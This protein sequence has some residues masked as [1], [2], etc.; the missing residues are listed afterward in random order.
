MLYYTLVKSQK[1][2]TEVVTFIYSSGMAR[3]L[4]FWSDGAYEQYIIL[5]QVGSNNDG[6]QTKRVFTG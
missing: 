1:Y 4:L 2:E 3:W 5:G 6:L